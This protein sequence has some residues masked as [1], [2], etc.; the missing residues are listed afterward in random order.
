MRVKGTRGRFRRE[1]GATIDVDPA[2]GSMES[3]SPFVAPVCA[4]RESTLPFGRAYP[5]DRVLH[6]LYPGSKAKNNPNVTMPLFLSG[7]SHT[8]PLTES[9]ID[10][11]RPHFERLSS[12]TNTDG[13]VVPQQRLSQIALLHPEVLNCGHEG[14]DEARVLLSLLLCC[15]A[16]HNPTWKEQRIVKSRRLRKNVDVSLREG[17]WLSDLKIRACT[18][19]P[20]KDNKPQKMV[21]NA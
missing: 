4:W 11:R 6:D 10:L 7:M 20:R 17:L 18:P 15:V 16:K 2:S 3:R 1:A 5:P 9:T 21:P 8:D 14:L 13:V 19:V 12:T